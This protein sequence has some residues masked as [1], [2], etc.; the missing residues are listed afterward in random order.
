METLIKQPEIVRLSPITIS[1]IAAGEVVDRPASVIKE[2]V[3]NSLDAG[4]SEIVIRIENVGKDLIS[5][6]DNGCG[7][8]AKNLG[9]AVKSHTT[10]KLKGDDLINIESLGFR[11][12]AIASIAAVSRLTITSRPSHM[13]EG[14]SISVIGGQEMAVVPAPHHVGTTI[15]IRDLFYATPAR[16]KFLKAD[17]TETQHIEAIINKIAIAYPK[18][19]FK[20]YVD[21]HLTLNYSTEELIDSRASRISDVLG[22]TFFE[23][24]IAING[25]N[26]GGRIS[27]YACL[28]T[29]A[30]STYAEQYLYINNR[31]VRDKLL[32]IYIKAAYQDFLGHDRYPVTVLFLDLPSEFV[33]VN[34]HPSKT[35]VRFRDAFS[36]KQLVVGSLKRA[37]E[38]NA[39]RTSSTVGIAALNALANSVEGS[40]P[41]K[42]YGPSN[43]NLF[44]SPVYGSRV[45]HQLNEA[46]HS[47][48]MPRASEGQQYLEPRTTGLQLE[49]TQEKLFRDTSLLGVPK[50]QL[51][52]TY[53]ISQTHDGLVIVDQH[54]AHERIRYER[55]KQ[56]MKEGTIESQQLLVPELV[57][58]DNLDLQD[59]LL[60][61]QDQLLKS[62]LKIEYHAKK[63][64]KVTEAPSLLKGCDIKELIHKV[65]NN[66]LDLE[67]DAN[68]EIFTNKIL[69]TYA[70][71]FSIRAGYEMRVEEMDRLLREMET[72]QSIGQCNHGR[73]TYIELKL[74][75]IKKLFERS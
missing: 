44:Q 74:K 71:H 63:V 39:T 68:L 70:C 27:G 58:L 26:D 19:V 22:K 28:P 69:S 50:A 54:A 30:R 3:E 45:P 56:Q 51:H 59:R 12:E 24:S 42:S 57:E 41:L 40:I 49:E 73:P 34:V 25:S 9:L 20:F 72:T 7:M 62:G 60:Q 48:N 37:L 65:I 31:A 29:Y 18:V 66:I 10:S 16:L 33:D 15:E 75:D 21:G 61:M 14:S 36:I 52:Q 13:A 38:E 6:S 53:I 47:F 35:E 23:N 55:L 32:L 17:R 8:D 1:R 2:L 67:D 5:V 4:S 64:I 46:I 11:G 43:T